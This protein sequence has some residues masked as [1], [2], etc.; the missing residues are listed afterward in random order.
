MQLTSRILA[1][2]IALAYLL[3]AAI[4]EGWTH[5]FGGIAIYL[6]VALALI[7]FP[8][9]IGDFTGHYRAQITAPTPGILISLAGWFF[10]VGMPVICFLLRREL[11]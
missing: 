10:L 9:E 7:W 4:S 3:A 2:L 6:T 5:E 8:D 1:V 11:G